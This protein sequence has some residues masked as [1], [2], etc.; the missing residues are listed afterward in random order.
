M[1]S[2]WRL[3]SL[4]LAVLLAATTPADDAEFDRA[5]AAARAKD[6]AKAAEYYRKAIAINP[7]MDD[8]RRYLA[9][10]QQSRP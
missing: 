6:Y 2:V 8:A 10:A 9:L 1:N 3:F 4:A 5:L 7:Q